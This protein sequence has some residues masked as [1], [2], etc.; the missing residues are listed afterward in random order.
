MRS[1]ENGGD[2]RLFVLGLDGTPP[3][4]LFDR[5]LPVMPNVRRLL[6]RGRRAA[7]RTTDPPIS[8]PAWPV[9]FTG[10]DPGSLG[11]YGFR[12]RRRGSYTDMTLPVSTDVPVRSVWELLSAA[13]LRVA[14]IGMPLGYPAPEVNGL[15]VSDF[16]TPPNGERTTYPP[17]LRAEI[18]AKHGTYQF[19]AVF[20]HGSRER[21]AQEI[22]EMTERR[23]R[24]AE[25]LY[26]REPW[27]VFALHEVGTDR[28]HHAFWKHFDPTDPAYVPG[29]PFA[30]LA[31]RYY[32][33]LD[34]GFG[35]LLAMADDRTD[36]MIV[37]DHG[38][39]AMRG[40][41]CINQWLEERGYLVLNHPPAG[42][43]T[44]FEKVDVDW[45]RTTV[46]GAGG[47]YARLWFNLVGREPNGTLTPPQAADLRDR[48]VE[49]LG[50]IE[51]PQGGPLPV[52][53]LDPHDLY[54]AVTREAPD[55]MVYFGDLRFRS[56]ATMGHDA[57][58][59]PENDVGPDDAVHSLHG[60]FLYAPARGTVPAELPPFPLIDVAPTILRLM[61]AP[62]PGYIQGRAVDAVLAPSMPA[63]KV[64]PSA[65]AT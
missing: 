31:E 1:P 17:G 24:V 51:D 54:H 57:L 59:L 28:L 39:M 44:P 33:L 32:A 38:S 42:P 10:V 40:C 41:F 4:F 26:A 6:E 20:R 60:V 30:D 15:Y 46:W 36:V 35:R 19:D 11:L 45:S 58:M 7:L 37:S 27:D 48:L 14:V 63:L 2:R 29:N 56:A 61:G 65:V 62:V 5:M 25:D 8:V 18:D 3:E 55:L 16:L 22:F 50:T 43:G 47:Y 49:E 9:M 34:E 64:E 21:V 53:V 52:Q 23:F 13:G 12:H